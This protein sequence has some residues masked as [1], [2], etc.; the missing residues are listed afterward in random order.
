MQSQSIL[1][2]SLRLSGESFHYRACACDSCRL[3]T[4]NKNQVKANANSWSQG[5]N[6]LTT[7]GLIS[8]SFASHTEAILN[9]GAGEVL[10]Y[11]I[12]NGLGF[13]DFEDY[14][15]GYSLGHSSQEETFIRN[16][17]S[18][19]DRLIDLDFR[20]ANNWNNSAF[21][22]Y[23]LGFYSQWS[24][25]TV[26]QVNDQGYGWGSYWDIYWKDTNGS[27]PLNSF[28]SMTIIHEIGHALG[29]SH[30]Y[31]DPAN[32]NWNT[33]DTIMSYN[34]SPDGWDVW[35]SDLDIAALIK[36]WGVENDNGRGFNGTSAS[37]NLRGT[38]SNDIIAG[39][40]G[41]DQ[42]TGIRGADTMLGYEG[43]DI[44]RAGNGG[45]YIWGGRG[46]DDLYGGFGH[47]TFGNERDGLIDWLFFK[48]DQFAYNWVYGKTG[49]NPTGRKVDLLK[50]LDSFDRIFVQGVDSTELSFSQVSNFTAPSGKFSGIGIF[51]N[52][53]LEGL[54]TGGDLSVE[55]LKSMTVG[56]DA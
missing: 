48:S 45:D 43:R 27:N 33:D 23:C 50:R 40:A 3:L 9:A 46:A 22:I 36:M 29:L 1:S 49:N 10:Q 24:D 18:K 21:D 47:N 34:S 26:G 20:E 17:F 2:D 37:D 15:Y 38:N 5:A 44:I 42:L 6:Y 41:S 8:D 7:D 16:A 35:F 30:P 32:G 54:Y 53:Y 55:Q 31:E 52:G 28:D 12:Y 19:I 11:F 56:V 25:F 13:V 4:E 39:Y 51:A 14:S